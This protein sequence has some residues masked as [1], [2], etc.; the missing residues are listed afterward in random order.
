MLR[1]TRAALDV[2]AQAQNFED[3][4]HRAQRHLMAL[5]S[6]QLCKQAAADPCQLARLDERQ[7]DFL[8]PLADEV[9]KVAGSVDEHG[10]FLLR[11]GNIGLVGSPFAPFT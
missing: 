1:F 3:A 8:P 6:F 2:H 9:A 10:D 4:Q 11:K 7:P 5:P